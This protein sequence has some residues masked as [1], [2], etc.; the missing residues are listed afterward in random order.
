MKELNTL[1]KFFKGK[2]QK[3]FFVVIDMENSV[4]LVL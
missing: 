1:F 3:Q 2:L 4:D